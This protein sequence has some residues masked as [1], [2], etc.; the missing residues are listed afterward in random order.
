LKL[1][2]CKDLCNVNFNNRKVLFGILLTVRYIY[3]NSY[4]LIYIR[5]LINIK[6]II[7]TDILFRR[8]RYILIKNELVVFIFSL[9]NYIPYNIFIKDLNLFR[10]SY[11]KYCVIILNTNYVTL[12]L[13]KKIF[14]ILKEHLYDVGCYVKIIY[15]LNNEYKEMVLSRKWVI[16]VSDKVLYKIMELNGVY[17][18][19]FV[20]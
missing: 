1:D 18:V 5:D 8:Y 4:V 14:I 10:L 13:L 11:S 3:G 12:N 9:R 2:L 20:Y 6:C 15:I 16:K 7:I 19:K 17:N